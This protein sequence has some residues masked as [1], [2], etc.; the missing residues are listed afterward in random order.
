MFV[1]ELNVLDNYDYNFCCA[2]SMYFMRV[3]LVNRGS[4]VVTC[5]DFI[6]LY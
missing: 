3:V 6:T 1:K 4:E 2:R 5:N